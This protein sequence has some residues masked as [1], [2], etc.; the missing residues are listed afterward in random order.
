MPRYWVIA[1]FQS[2]LPGLY[3]KVW[4]F[5][6]ENNLISIGWDL[7]G[8]VSTMSRESLD[9]S[10]ATAYSDKPSSTRS[11]IANMIWNFWHEISLGDFVIARKGRTALAAIGKVTRSGFYAPGKNP[12][13]ASPDHAHSGFLGVDWQGQPRNKKYSRIVFPMHT[14]M[15]ISEIN[16]HDFAEEGSTPIDNLQISEI[17]EAIE[18]PSVFVLEKYLQDFI[19][20]NFETIFKGS[21][22]MYE[23]GTGADGQQ[24]DTDIG[25][26]DILAFEPKTNSFVVIE[27]KRGSTSDQVVGQTLRYMGWVKDRLCKDGQ[28]VKGLIICLESDSKLD[29]AIKMTNNIDVRYYK[30]GFKLMETP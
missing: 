27:L 1:P 30:V 2:T 3:E 28:Q 10:V 15:E 25:R 6:L 18:D 8:D 4:Q 16:Y 19:A 11:L 17:A 13:L 12:F 24:Y 29:Y 14:L 21:M 7:F 9:D 20:S 5:D 26:I 23:D 22:R